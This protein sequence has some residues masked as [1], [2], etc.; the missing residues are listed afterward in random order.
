MKN[1][2]DEVI[3]LVNDTYLWDVQYKC[4]ELLEQ[5]RPYV[6]VGERL[7]NNIVQTVEEDK[8]TDKDLKEV[9]DDFVYIRY[10]QIKEQTN[11]KQ[12]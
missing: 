6:E 2:I 3:E 5:L 11:E 4:V 12:D 1:K 8:L 7:L 10:K 9:L